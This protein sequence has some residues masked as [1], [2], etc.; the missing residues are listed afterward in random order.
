MYIWEGHVTHLAKDHVIYVTKDYDIL[1]KGHV[2]YLNDRPHYI[3]HVCHNAIR[4]DMEHQET[5]NNR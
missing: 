1:M 4:H 3:T 5:I 2:T